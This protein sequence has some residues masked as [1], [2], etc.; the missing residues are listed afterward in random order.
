MNIDENN[1]FKTYHPQN[2]GLNHTPV[3]AFAEDQQYLWVGT[4]GGG[5]NRMNKATGEFSYITSANSITSNNIKSLITDA[6]HN[7]WISTFMGGLDLY[8]VGRQK[9]TNFKHT[10]GAP[11]SLLVNDVRKTILEGDSGMWVAYQYQKAEVSYFSFELKVSTIHIVC[12]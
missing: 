2:S 7:L 5:I 8:N 10:K 1:A 3:S 9:V 11:H 6:G 4:E 12:D